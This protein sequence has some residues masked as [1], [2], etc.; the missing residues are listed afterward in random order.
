VTSTK[1]LTLG[2][3]SSVGVSLN[4]KNRYVC[5]ARHSGDDGQVAQK[6]NRL[7]YWVATLIGFLTSD[8]ESQSD[9]NAAHAKA[10]AAQLVS[11]FERFAGPAMRLR[12]QRPLPLGPMPLN[13]EL[14]AASARFLVAAG[15]LANLGRLF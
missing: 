14:A 15:S 2:A 5:A 10:H 4:A 12:D 3:L 13:L 6:H 9:Q 11:R 1:L 8:W 7:P